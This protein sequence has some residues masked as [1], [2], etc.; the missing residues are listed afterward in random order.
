VNDLLGRAVAAEERVR[1]LEGAPQTWST[2]DPR[3]T[4]GKRARIVVIA[5]D[6]VAVGNV[7]TKHGYFISLDHNDPDE[8]RFVG[9]DESWPGWFWSRMPSR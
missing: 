3:E 9:E 4:I 5:G 7:E 8:R 6:R 1:Q 2:R